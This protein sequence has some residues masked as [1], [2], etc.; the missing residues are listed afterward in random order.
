M[1]SH[2]KYSLHICHWTL[3]QKEK[4]SQQHIHEIICHP[5][6]CRFTHTSKYI[7]TVARTT[8]C[9]PWPGNNSDSHLTA[10][11][12]KLNQALL[13]LQHVRPKRYDFCIYIVNYKYCHHTLFAQSLLVAWLAR[14]HAQALQNLAL[15]K[16]LATEKL[17]AFVEGRAKSKWETKTP[18]KP[19]QNRLSLS[20][21]NGASSQRH[22]I[23]LVY[24]GSNV[25][26]QFQ[27]L[28]LRVDEFLVVVQHRL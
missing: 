16:R 5:T 1:L 10:T 7:C 19:P 11:Q 15:V 26:C 22:A 20:N 21:R 25:L 9:R 28:Q 6:T 18:R 23:Q 12:F 27:P 3:T 14:K 24:L 13:L 8:F 4:Q 2:R 17:Q